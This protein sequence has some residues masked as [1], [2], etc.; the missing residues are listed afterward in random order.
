MNRTCNLSS[1]F[2][3]FAHLHS[4]QDIEWHTFKE[5]SHKQIKQRKHMHALQRMRSEGQRGGNAVSPALH[6]AQVFLL[7]SS[8][9]LITDSLQPGNCQL[10]RANYKKKQKK[11]TRPLIVTELWCFVPSCLT[12]ESKE[13]WHGAE[14]HIAE[15]R[16]KEKFSHS[17][18]VFPV[19]STREGNMLSALH[20]I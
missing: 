15:K 9:R 1:T 3:V 14:K 20:L 18:L 4:F 8:A 11:S 5:T 16:E 7:L 19:V 6:T 2:P 10:F 17:M 12:L 13:C